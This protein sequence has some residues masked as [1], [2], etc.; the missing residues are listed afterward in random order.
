MNRQTHTAWFD[1]L[2]WG[3]IW[4]YQKAVSNPLHELL[5]K[6]KKLAGELEGILFI[7]SARGEEIE[8]AGNKLY[9]GNITVKFEYNAEKPMPQLIEEYILPQLVE[10]YIKPYLESDKCALLTEMHG[11]DYLIT[12]AIQMITEQAAVMEK[13]K[14]IG[15]VNIPPEFINAIL[16]ARPVD[17]P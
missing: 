8:L 11:S 2:Y 1:C 4:D 12:R 16:S 17:T 15:G 9:H 6:E 14:E 13:V 7:S 5:Q 10:T 3:T